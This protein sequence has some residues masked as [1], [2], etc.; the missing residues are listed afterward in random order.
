MY[1]SIS[2]RSSVSGSPG[3]ALYT[4]CMKSVRRWGCFVPL[5]VVALILLAIIVF[6]IIAVVNFSHSNFFNLNFDRTVGCS[7]NPPIYLG[8]QIHRLCRNRC[9]PEPHRHRHRR[10]LCYCDMDSVE[11][12]LRHRDHLCGRQYRQFAFINN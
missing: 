5:G 9:E 1:A 7:S 3:R 10:C 2:M 6:V 8:R 12:E 11:G 4:L